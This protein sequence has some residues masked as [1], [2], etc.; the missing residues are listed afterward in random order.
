MKIPLTQGKFA[1]VD[2]QD[3]KRINQYKW[4]IFSQKGYAVRDK[5]VN[6]KK[7][8]ISMH[9]YIMK[10][11]KEMEVDH[12]NGN[13]LDNRR[14]NLRI[15]T[16]QQNCSNRKG[17]NK[18]RGFTKRKDKFLKKPYCA[19]IMVNYKNLYLGYYATPEEAAKTYDKAAKKYFGEFAQLNFP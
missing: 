14:K 17:I 15:C 12:I 16:H 19:R 18:L 9:R 1:L 10:P 11:P 2:K 8:K 13:V 5:V 4:H 3:F 7:K 6:G